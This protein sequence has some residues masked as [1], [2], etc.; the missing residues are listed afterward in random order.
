MSKAKNPTKLQSAKSFVKKPTARAA[1]KAVGGDF[2]V[3]MDSDADLLDKNNEGWDDL[4]SLKENLANALVEF[5]IQ[6]QSIVTSPEITSR[7]GDKRAEFDKLV[8]VFNVDVNSFASR[9]EELRAQHEDKTGSVTSIDDMN[10]FSNLGMKYQVLQV[11]I[12]SLLAP[13]LAG[14]VMIV[15]D[16]ISDDRSNQQS[17]QDSA[18]VDVQ[19]KEISNVH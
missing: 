7:L 4:N 9:I 19:P 11:E 6:V 15:N 18:V 3:D 16:I 1:Q 5:V 12:N 17:L 14:L 2:T 8:T 10:T 13:T